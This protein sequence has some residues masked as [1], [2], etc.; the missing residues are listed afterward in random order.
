MP[1]SSRGAAPDA[2]AGADADA[3]CVRMSEVCATPAE[4]QALFEFPPPELADGGD[5]GIDGGDGGLVCPSASTFRGCSMPGCPRFPT[6]N[7]NCSSPVQDLPS[8]NGMCCY[9]VADTFFCPEACG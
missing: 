5:A 1:D 8:M 3:N 2:E 4:L 9:V 6:M 7:D